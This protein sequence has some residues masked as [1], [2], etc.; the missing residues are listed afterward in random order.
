MIMHHDVKL[1]VS[2]S[3]QWT[4]TPLKAGAAASSLDIQGDHREV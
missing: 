4:L 2:P 3:D 1:F